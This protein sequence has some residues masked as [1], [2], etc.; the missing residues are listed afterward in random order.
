VL[1]ASGN[2]FTNTATPPDH[3]S[4]Y[5]SPVMGPAWVTR[6]GAADPQSGGPSWW[7]CLPVDVL[8]RSG[9]LAPTFDSMDAMAPQIG[10]SVSAPNVA[11]HVAQLLLAARRAG[12]DADARDATERLLHAAQPV[13][14]TPGLGRD[15]D[16]GALSPFD[17]GYGLADDA[18]LARARDALLR[19]QPPA[20]R[21]ELDSWFAQDRAIRDALWG[22][23]S[24]TAGPFG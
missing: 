20:P 18:A 19:S 21:H 23:G 22:P 14:Q 17:Q 1:D 6:V 13:A 16:L 12:L 2:G 9:V 11:S 4:T 7:H 15:P 10:T 24:L 5:T 3:C 8:G